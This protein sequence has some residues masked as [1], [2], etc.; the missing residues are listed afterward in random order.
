MLSDKQLSVGVVCGSRAAL[1]PSTTV[2]PTTHII[3]WPVGRE[4]QSMTV[5][6]TAN[7]EFMS[8]IGKI[9]GKATGVKKSRGDAA[10][11]AALNAKRKTKSGGRKPKE[12]A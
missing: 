5:K 7:P 4:R 9:G 3:A 1:R 8:S 6:P 12:P 10:Y 11:Y 2:I